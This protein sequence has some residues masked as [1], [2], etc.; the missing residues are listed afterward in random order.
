MKI[1]FS[2]RQM[3]GLYLV[4]VYVRVLCLRLASH[5]HIGALYSAIH[6]SCY[7]SPGAAKRL[8]G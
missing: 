2:I 6:S 4:C 8:V 7:I 1:V 5:A 3:R